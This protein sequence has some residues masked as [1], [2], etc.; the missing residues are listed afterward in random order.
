MQEL[1]KNPGKFYAGQDG[2]G[3]QETFEWEFSKFDSSQGVRKIIWILISVLKDC[4]MWNQLDDDHKRCLA[5]YHMTLL[6][7]SDLLNQNWTHHFGQFKSELQRIGCVLKRT[8]APG[9]NERALRQHR[10][11][12]ALQRGDRQTAQ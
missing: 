7:N 1:H 10:K 9:Q 11:Y 2:S 8:C 6:L 4:T 12:Y 5:D 3:V